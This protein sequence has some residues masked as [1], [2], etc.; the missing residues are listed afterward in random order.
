M[1]WMQI[2]AALALVMFIVVLFPRARHMIK[3]SP[4]G[5][6]SDWMSFVI[7]IAAVVLFV[8]LLIKLV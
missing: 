3:N 6:S 8:M 7:P 5:T 4:K 2:I 1:D